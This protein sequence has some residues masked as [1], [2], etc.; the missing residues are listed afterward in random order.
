MADTLKSIN[1]KYTGSVDE[2]VKVKTLLG[3]EMFNYSAPVDLSEALEVDEEAGIFSVYK[4]KRKTNFQD[5]IR[6]WRNGQ[7][8]DALKAN[9]AKLAALLATA[10]VDEIYAEDA[11]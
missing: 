6:K 7:I 8:I 9:P 11:D 2:N 5:A 4:V 10:P 3:D 1:A